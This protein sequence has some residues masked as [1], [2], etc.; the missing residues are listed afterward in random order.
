MVNWYL[1]E[2]KT[3]LPFQIFWFG[4]GFHAAN[5]KWDRPRKFTLD[6]KTRSWGENQKKTRKALKEMKLFEAFLL[7]NSILGQKNGRRTAEEAGSPLPADY[8]DERYYASNNKPNK[9]DSFESK[10]DQ[11]AIAKALPSLF[12]QKFIKKFI[13]IIHTENLWKPSN[14]NNQ[15]YETY[16]DP[17]FM[18]Q[19]LGSEPICFDYNPPPGTQ[20]TLLSD[21]E[22][23]MIVTG[24]VWPHLA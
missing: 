23:G 11:M 10:S 21:P 2:T 14:N 19:S 16:G 9:K 7:V 17:H 22:S 12:S 15:N 24:K 1:T 13:K 20:I 5:I 8:N 6:K 18:V 3:F 4:F